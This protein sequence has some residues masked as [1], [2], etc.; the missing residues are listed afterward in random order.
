MGL[1]LTSI[2]ARD[3]PDA[4][5]QAVDRVLT[6]GRQW[7]VTHGSYE[8]QKRWE[9][10][11]V[12]I[13]ILYPGTRP[14]V[15]EMP[16]HLSHIP[17]PTTMEHVEAYLPYL[18]TDQPL[19]INELY[20]YGQRLAP[21][22]EAIIRRYKEHGFGSNQEC[23]TVARPED[24]KL[25]DPPCLRQIDIRIVT[26]DGL[27]EGESFALHFIVYFRSNDLW[28]AFPIN[29]ASIRLL[30]EY[31]AECIG[32]EAGEIVYA[33]KGLH[34]YDFSFDVAKLRVGAV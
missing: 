6:E 17:P 15:P 27:R 4:W 33:S 34:L 21:Q 22:I 2:Q 31:M 19:K 9:L 30:Q 20:S 11:Y 24:L 14:L 5:F 32:V 23:M 12:T 10:D 3:L 29:L 28:N 1:K 13:H 7:T 16:V 25:A 8:G 18:M 26:K